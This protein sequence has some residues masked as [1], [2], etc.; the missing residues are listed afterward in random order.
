LIVETSGI[1]NPRDAAGLLRQ[2]GLDSEYRIARII[3]LAAPNNLLQLKEVV[4]NIGEQV[5]AADTILLNKCDTVSAQ[6]LDRV[7]LEILKINPTAELY[8]TTYARVDLDPLEFRPP[9]PEDAVCL[10]TSNPFSALE[11]EVRQAVEQRHIEAI[12]SRLGSALMRVKGCIPTNQGFCRVDYSDGNWS[13]TAEKAESNQA[14][15]LVVIVPDDAEK[16]A[17]TFLNQL[18]PLT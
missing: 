13:W 7:E 14:G 4:P 8:R 17:E 15:R 12:L 3:C 11:L 18:Q 10:A 9:R 6:E 5:R 16:E 1:S 2:T